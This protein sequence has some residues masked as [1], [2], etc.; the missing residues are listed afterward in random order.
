[1]STR[2]ALASVLLCSLPLVAC[3]SE[4][5]AGKAAGTS[6]ATGKGSGS[7]APQPDRDVPPPRADVAPA[8]SDAPTIPPAP[9]P[10]IATEKDC[11]EIVAYFGAGF[12]EVAD[13]YKVPDAGR[14]Q[15]QA[16]LLEAFGSGCK[17]DQWPVALI[18][19][20]GKQPTEK[21]TYQRCIERLPAAQRLLWDTKLSAVVEAAGGPK[22]TPAV[23]GTPPAGKAFEEIC[24]GF[25]AEMA[26]LDRCTAAGAYIPALES[27][28]AE[29]RA[30]EVGGV[31]PE[32]HVGRIGASCAKR[33]AAI[34]KMLPQVCPDVARGQ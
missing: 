17:T 27:V 25:V 6:A 10:G 20:M 5:S 32:E 19:C 24:R 21:F 3:K 30:V 15:A 13:L 22:V 12:F 23:T 34:L 4:S 33:E 18:D 8:T 14:V 1:M 28:Y 2:L 9:P 31:I 29:R 7:A 11:D 26:R 16:A